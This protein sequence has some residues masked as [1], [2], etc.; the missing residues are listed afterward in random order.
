[1]D[2][3]GKGYLVIVVIVLVVVIVLGR[4]LCYVIVI[5]IGLIHKH[6]I[7]I[8]EWCNST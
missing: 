4:G 6:G 2:A 3:A 5:I 8:T 1:M 7:L